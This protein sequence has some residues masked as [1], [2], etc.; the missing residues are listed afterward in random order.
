M[1]LGMKN[2]QRLP[3]PNPEDWTDAA[4]AAAILGKSRGT[5]YDMSTRGVLTAYVIGAGRVLFW[6]PEVQE[7]ARSLK[8]L[9]A[10]A[11]VSGA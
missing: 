7:V 10:G 1:L 3:I 5:V 2:E 9:E 11:A 4:G 8:R 6:V